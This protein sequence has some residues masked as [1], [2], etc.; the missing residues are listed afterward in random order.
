M[1]MK[2]SAIIVILVVAVL[3]IN[4]VTLGMNIYSLTITG[5]ASSDTASVSLY[6]QSSGAPAGSTTVAPTRA[7]TG[8]GENYGAK[9]A[10]SNGTAPYAN[11]IVP[12][13]E[14]PLPVN[15]T[16]DV[17]PLLGMLGLIVLMLVIMWLIIKHMLK[18]KA[19]KKAKSRGKTRRKK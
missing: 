1:I 4:I 17:Y 3:L 12:E 8:G 11:Q 2:K 14:S 7:S 18:E 10:A 9:G 5:G 19:K 6:V 13:K 15:K 16:F